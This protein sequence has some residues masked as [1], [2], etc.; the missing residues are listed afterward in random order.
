MTSQTLSNSDQSPPE[1]SRLIAIDRIGREPLVETIEATVAERA[2]LAH[3]FDL[4][5]V[6]I[7]TARVTL[8]RL[9]ANSVIRMT[10]EYQAQCDQKCVVTLEPVPATIT[11]SCSCDFVLISEEEMQEGGTSEINFD[12]LDEDTELLTEAEID[13]GEVIAQYFFLSLPPYPRQPGA[14]IPN[15]SGKNIN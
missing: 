12:V 13:I 3:R 9:R 15:P 5:S 14:E 1:F 6:S 4:I 7:L 10:A 11:D 2:A 8:R